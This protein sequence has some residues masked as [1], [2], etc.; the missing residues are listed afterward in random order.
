MAQQPQDW[1]GIGQGDPFLGV[2]AENSPENRFVMA[3]LQ[4]VI[5]VLAGVFGFIGVLLPHAPDYN[6]IGL[7]AIQAVA[8]AAGVVMYALGGRVSLAFLRY[9]PPVS[10]LLTTLAIYYTRDVESAYALFFLWNTIYVLYFFSAREAMANVVIASAAYVFAFVITPGTSLAAPG[11]AYH[12]VLTAMT[13]ALPA[14][15]LMNLRSRV[16]RLIARLTDSARIDALTG[17]RN[18]QG[19]TEILDN[20]LERCRVPGHALTVLIADL[21]GFKRVNKELGTRGGDVRLTEVARFLRDFARP[22][23]TVARTGGEEFGLICPDLDQHEAYLMGERMLRALRSDQHDR[24]FPVSMSVGVATF[25][26]Q[27][28][29]ASELLRSADEAMHAAKAL[30]RDRVV[31][32][33]PEISSVFGDL[34][35]ASDQG[36]HAQLSAVLGLA[37]ALDARDSYT[38]R[39]SQTVGRYSELMARKLGLSEDR[40]ERVRLAGMVHDIGKVGV[41]DSILNKPGK[42]DDIEWEQMRRHPEIGA[43]ILE[44]EGLEDI[45]SWVMAHHER[46]DGRGYPLGLEDSQIAVEAKIL[47]VADAYE[48]MTSDRP[49]R[50]A[51]GQEIAIGELRKHAGG[52]FDEAVIDAFLAVL[53]LGGA[54][55]EIDEPTYRSDAIA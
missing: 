41:P 43:R 17:L 18:R 11:V 15:A 52:Q 10:S 34:T 36:A 1:S 7:I 39:H 23:D 33:S 9:T 16:L 8:A 22:Q 31:L 20:E 4:G 55:I 12:L 51:L 24:P 46:P 50:K 21:D 32:F 25:P 44:G 45:R 48:A 19:F 35:I 6:E 30:G 47:S 49:Y 14:W 28:E 54:E 29:G 40:I 37:G 42:L 2:G 53:K 26:A 5:L 27:G 3:R 38:A 13:L